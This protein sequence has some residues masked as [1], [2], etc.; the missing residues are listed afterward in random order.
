[1]SPR[2]WLDYGN[3]ARNGWSPPNSA[4]ASQPRTLWAR[5]FKFS[6]FRLRS[7]VYVRLYRRPRS[8]AETS[9]MEDLQREEIGSVVD[10]TI[11]NLLMAA[12]VEAPPV[13]A[14]ALAR[15]HL[16]M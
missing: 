14:I 10:D 7:G 15:G 8:A 5:C 9:I 3:S 1:T 11:A 6:C 2:P 13:D 12:H 4:G 16:G